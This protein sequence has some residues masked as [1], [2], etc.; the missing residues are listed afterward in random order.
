MHTAHCARN[1]TL[2]QV[3]KEPIPKN[4]FEDHK[5]KCVAVKPK[6][7]KPQPVPTILENSSYFQE[8]KSVEDKKVATRN[9]R[10]MQKLDR[11][12][13]SGYSLK[14]VSGN[15][16]TQRK[17]VAVNNEIQKT[18]ATPKAVLPDSQ[19]KTKTSSG[20][21]ACKYCDLELPK[22]ELEDHENYCGSRTDKCLQCGE[23]VMFK[24]KQIHM[25]S[26]HGFLKLNDGKCNEM[27]DFTPI[28]PYLQFKTLPKI[29]FYSEL[30]LLIY[31]RPLSCV[32]V[33][34]Q[35][36]PNLNGHIA[37]KYEIM[38]LEIYWEQTF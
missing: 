23:L 2:C 35:F 12:V 14:S 5:K 34:F 31:P 37:Y 28:R 4:Q 15:K 20:L 18:N 1:I 38:I 3:C 9:E 33:G 19:T 21:L 16:E 13:D 26:N 22:L 24:Y 10:R 11:L 7:K 8:R 32:I 27:L 17:D 29:C 6:E 25:D 30:F 36:P